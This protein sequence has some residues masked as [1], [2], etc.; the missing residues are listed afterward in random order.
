MIYYGEMV[1]MNQLVPVFSLII[2][3]DLLPGVFWH[4]RQEG[5]NS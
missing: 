2:D 3:F 4:F 5:R 1:A